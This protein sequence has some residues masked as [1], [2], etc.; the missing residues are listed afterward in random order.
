MTLLQATLPLPWQPP[1]TLCSDLHKEIA[2]G[3]RKRKGRERASLTPEINSRVSSSRVGLKV[4][5]LL[6][7]SPV[8]AD[9]ARHTF[10]RKE[11]FSLFMPVSG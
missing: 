9:L 8:Q 3:A 5:Y 11:G 2:K 6:V 4:L 10:H 1:L 7:P